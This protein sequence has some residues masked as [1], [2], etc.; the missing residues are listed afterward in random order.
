MKKNYAWMMSAIQLLVLTIAFC[1]TTI[2]TSCDNDDKYSSDNTIKFDFNGQESLNSLLQIVKADLEA[3]DFKELISL[4]DALRND[5]AKVN[6]TGRDSTGVQQITTSLQS[7]LDSF[8]N[9]ENPRAFETSWNFSNLSKTLQMAANVSMALEKDAENKYWGKRNYSEAFDIVV[10]DT[11]TYTITLD[12]EKNTGVSLAEAAN[13]AHRK[14][15]IGKNGSKV[16]VVDTNHDL[17]ASMNGF[18]IN[19]TQQTISSLDYKDMKFSLVR[20]QF[21]LDSVASNII[22]SKEG[23]EVIGLKYD[24]DNISKFYVAGLGL[25]GIALT[26][27]SKENCQ[28]LTDAFNA[29]VSS[30]LSL[31]GDE[32]GLLMLE[33]LASDSLPDVYR[34]TLYLLTNPTEEGGEKYL[35]KDLMEMMGLTFM[36]LIQ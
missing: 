19:A 15:T 20:T 31:L 5:S 23:S 36:N 8:F 2:L 24:I 26:G 9:S 25:A 28:K 11:L 7:L 29:V 21:N 27:S 34:P 33:P 4:L 13:D 16:L 22:Y 1:G 14:L 18:N 6:W 35:L 17:D 12:I 30:K 32:Q 3:A 10:N